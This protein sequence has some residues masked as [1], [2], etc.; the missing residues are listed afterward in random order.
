MF[1]QTFYELDFAD[2]PKSDELCKIPVLRF[3]IRHQEAMAIILINGYRLNWY[4]A[5]LNFNKDIGFTMS[6][7]T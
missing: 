4:S 2:T 6:Y 1:N 7:F 5:P 3:K